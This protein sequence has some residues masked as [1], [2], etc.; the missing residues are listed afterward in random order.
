MVLPFPTRTR[1]DIIVVDPVTFA[2]IAVDFQRTF[3]M[4]GGLGV[5]G[6]HELTIPGLRLIR[7]FARNRRISTQDLHPFG[8]ISLASSY[9]GLQPF[10]SLSMGEVEDWTAESHRIAP[11]ALFTL[12]E[13]KDYLRLV[14]E[15][16]L[17][18]DH[19]IEGEEETRVVPE[20]LWESTKV[21]TKGDRPH[22][23]SYS[24]FKEN[25]GDST[26]LGPYLACRGVRRNV[27]W[28]IA[29]DVCL[30]F[31]ALDSAEEGF[32]TYVVTDLCPAITQD[33]A[34]AMT[35]RLT[36]A[37]VHLVTSDQIRAAA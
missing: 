5:S 35:E 22:R 2:V 27:L 34:D 29:Y 12:D 17:W 13:L 18:P 21:W 31:S 32:E 4:G 25:G 28:G 26:R 14:V 30:G 3:M 33:G 19:A 6:G 8:H 16:V 15:Q 37:G 7:K 1:D 10:H 23:D 9:V 11:H 36:R 20:I 24:A